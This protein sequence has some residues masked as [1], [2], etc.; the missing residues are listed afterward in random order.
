MSLAGYLFL[1]L[2]GLLGLTGFLFFWFPLLGAPLIVLGGA[3]FFVGRVLI[4]EGRRRAVR[5]QLGV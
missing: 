3:S 5:R 4:R 1:G 2:G